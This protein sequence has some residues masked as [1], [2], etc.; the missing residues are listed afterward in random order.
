MATRKASTSSV[1]GLKYTDASAGTSKIADVP[2]APTP[3]TPVPGSTGVG[4]GPG[5]MS[6][7]FTAAT[8]GGIA[9]S[10]VA[11][12]TPGSITGSSS[13]SPITVSGL[14]G[15]TSYGFTINAINS[16]GTSSNNQ[17]SSSATA[18]SEYASVQTFNSSGSFTIPAGKSL[19]A[20]SGWGSGGAGGGGETAEWFGNFQSGSGGGGGNS[21][22]PFIIEDIP[23]NAG[24]IIT[25]TIGSNG[26]TSTVGNVISIPGGAGTITRNAGNITLGTAGGG[27]GGGGRRAYYTN[28][29]QQ[30][31]GAG[32]DSQI[33]TSNTAGISSITTILGGGG[34]GGGGGVNSNNNDAVQGALGGAGATGAGNG[35]QGTAFR[36]APNGVGN[37]A[38]QSG[39]GGGGG[40]GGDFSDS[41]DAAGGGS[42]GSARLYVYAK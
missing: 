21:G 37:S 41:S 30:Q 10:F 18:I 33:L 27:G 5:T 7:P 36:A 14:V 25:V 22:R 4:A 6:V 3:G 31:G 16:T 13:S 12:S 40:G 32:S 15:G 17:T 19:L 28:N 39:S 20:V 38:T 1:T 42:G 9:T 23:V 2:D 35:G 29:P 11:T 8:N 34:G 24:D 26:G